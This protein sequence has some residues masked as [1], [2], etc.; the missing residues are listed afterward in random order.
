MEVIPIGLI[1]EDEETPALETEMETL[2]GAITEPPTEESGGAMQAVALQQ[3]ANAN[4]EGGKELRHD[5][6]HPCQGLPTLT[7]RDEITQEHYPTTE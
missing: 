4:G 3:Y 6:G 5:S 7:I 1:V 2:L